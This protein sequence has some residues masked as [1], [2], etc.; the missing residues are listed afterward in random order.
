MDLY[1]LIVSRFRWCINEVILI[2]DLQ[3]EARFDPKKI[4]EIALVRTFVLLRH[5]ILNYFL[6]DFL[7]DINLRKKFLNF[8][9]S[10]YNVYPK[11]I[12]SSIINL[13]KAWVHCCKN[14]WENID[15]DE[16][17][18]IGHD[19]EWLIFQIKDITQLEEEK[20]RESRLSAYALQGITN[21]DSRNR[22]MLSLFKSSDNFKLPEATTKKDS[23]TSS[24]I[25]FPQDNLSR[26]VHPV[27]KSKIESKDETPEVVDQTITDG[28]TRKYKIGHL[29][30]LMNISTTIKDLDYPSTPGL[31]AIIPPTPAKNVEFILSSSYL[32]EDLDGSNLEVYPEIAERAKRASAP[33]LPSSYR[34]SS[35]AAFSNIG[36]IGLL[37]KWKQNH[38]NVNS[39]TASLNN[40]PSSSTSKPELDLFVKYVISI[41]LVEP[42]S[43]NSQ[44]YEKSISSKFDILSARTIDEVEYLI[45]TENQ[46]IQMMYLKDPKFDQN[47]GI[48]EEEDVPGEVTVGY[49]TMDNLNLYQTVSSIA[50]SVMSLSNTLN[51]KQQ[52]DSSPFNQKYQRRQVQSTADMIYIGKHYVDSSAKN[53]FDLTG[54]PEPFNDGPQRLIF[55]SKQDGIKKDVH[56]P[57]FDSE[58]NLMPTPLTSKRFSKK[59]GNGDSPLK[60]I[61]SATSN[62]T[63]ELENDS[64]SR[65]SSTVSYDS[66]LSAKNDGLTIPSKSLSNSFENDNDNKILKRKEAKDNLREF[67]FED[68]TSDFNRNIFNNPSTLTDGN[69]IKRGRLSM[70]NNNITNTAVRPASGRISIIKR[71]SEMI[72]KRKTTIS[73]VEYSISEDADYIEKENFL[74]ESEFELSAFEDIPHN[75]SRSPSIAT[76][77]LYHST[78]SSPQKQILEDEP[79]DS[80]RLSKSPSIKSIETGITLSSKNSSQP[81]QATPGN[82][83]QYLIPKLNKELNL[84]EQFLADKIPDMRR[85]SS[86]K[87]LEVNDILDE[88]SVKGFSRPNS[89]FVFSSDNESLDAASPE[90]DMEQLKKRFLNKKEAPID[91]NKQDNLENNEINTPSMPSSPKGLEAISCLPDDSIHDDPLAVALMKL[92]GTY[93]HTGDGNEGPENNFDSNLTDEINLL[94]IA[95]VPVIFNSNSNK[96]NSMFIRRRRQTIMNIPFTPESHKNIDLID[97]PSEGI[98]PLKIQELFNKYEIKDPSLLSDNRSNHIPF[99]LM[100]DSLSIARHLTMIEKELLVEIDWQELLDLKVSYEGLH[101]TSWLQL[102]IQNENLSGIDLV[103]SRFNLTVDWIVSE[104]ALLTDIKLKRNTI[105]RFIHVAEHCRKLQNYNTL[106]QII[107]ALNSSTVQ[108]FTEAWRLIEPGDLLS[109]EELK[110]IPSLDKNYSSIRHLLNEINPIEGCIPFI[111]VYLSDLSLNSEKRDWIVQNQVLNYNKF[112]TNVQIVKNFIQRVQ[113]SKFYNFEINQE[114]LSKCVYISTLTQ[115]EIQSFG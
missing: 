76:S 7:H 18:L 66:L 111:V 64:N 94:N 81:S 108:K 69:S 22:S 20:K 114:L 32:P 24:M 2:R 5:W 4:G 57:F 27:D 97:K 101:V 10:Q 1:D 85:G 86:N 54:S 73:L 23:K 82:S 109:W 42:N 103:I 41:S 110:L 113:W 36:P 29:S 83:K 13:K 49:S 40:F 98:T 11:I 65:G 93:K 47:N 9:N 90:K 91:E 6:H 77:E 43:T 62:N 105:Q 56:N 104:I 68:S 99:I 50:N 8:L 95:D 26:T 17:A 3:Y 112:E 53:S 75:K 35:D 72:N 100:Y 107:L 63:T 45:S 33:I 16:P 74:E 60:N 58:N 52:D 79:I 89:K 12:T 30:K 106:M 39:G 46:L 78:H 67:T 25:L 51:L 88:G 61:L 19:V 28:T 80:T 44:E 37:N 71:N 34:E 102:L 59:V 55:E 92:E 31:D 84:R 96:R 15:F 70:S 115:G 14:V 87:F 21:P 38:N 48:Q